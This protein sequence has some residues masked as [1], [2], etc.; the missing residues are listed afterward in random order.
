MRYST[1]EVEATRQRLLAQGGA[2]AKQ[3]GFGESGMAALASAAG[4]TTGSLYKHFQGKSDFF[5]ALV[6][7]ELQ[8][9][10]ALYEGIAPGDTAALRRA[11]LG[12]LSAAH[13]DNPQA[14]CPLPTL[15]PEVARAES[16]VRAAFDAGVQAIHAAVT[17]LVAE[18]DRAWVL[19]AQSVGAVMLARALQDPAMR[20]AL[21]DAVR[22][23]AQGLVA[24][25]A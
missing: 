12:Y 18:P 11:A 25:A 17:R 9:T 6:S 24:Q 1:D 3:H 13:I 5:A 16:E 15:T 10:A 21:L 7:A 22:A 23:S 8:R 19:M 20:D 14:G 4:V 2:H